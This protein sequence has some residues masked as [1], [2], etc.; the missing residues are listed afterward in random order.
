MIRS[1]P[2]CLAE[3]DC[4]EWESVRTGIG[5]GPPPLKDPHA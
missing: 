1:A 5:V 2:I 4:A 3:I